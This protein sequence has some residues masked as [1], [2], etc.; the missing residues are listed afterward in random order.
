MRKTQLV[1]N[2]EFASRVDSAWSGNSP[3]KNT[4]SSPI[5][6][7]LIRRIRRTLKSCC[8]AM[9]L[10]V[11]CKMSVKRY[12]ARSPLCYR[13]EHFSA[14]RQRERSTAI[15]RS[16]LCCDHHH[17][18]HLQHPVASRQGLKSLYGRFDSL[19]NPSL[20][21]QSRQLNYALFALAAT[22]AQLP[23]R[24]ARLTRT[25]ASWPQVTF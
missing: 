3:I 9:E 17:V 4:A 2:C 7:Q 6:Q 5:H 20:K 12:A 13:P 23:F 18:R 21:Q 1:R 14:E 8:R 25:S 15:R 19:M 16:Y 22:F 11:P 24:L 10:C